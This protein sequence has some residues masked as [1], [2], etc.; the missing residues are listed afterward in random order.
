MMLTPDDLT[1]S[2]SGEGLWADHPLHNALLNLVFKLPMKAFRECEPFKH[3][4][5]WTPCSA[6][7]THASFPSPQCVVNGQASLCL[8]RTQ[9]GFTAWGQWTDFTVLGPDSS[10]VQKE[11]T[12]GYRSLGRTWSTAAP[13][14]WLHVTVTGGNKGPW[15]NKGN[16]LNSDAGNLRGNKTRCRK[17][18]EMGFLCTHDPDWCRRVRPTQPPD[19]APRVTHQQF[20]KWLHPQTLKLGSHVHSLQGDFPPR[21][22]FGVTNPQSPGWTPFPDLETGVTYPQSPG[23]PPSPDPIPGVTCPQ[24][25]GWPLSLDPA[26]WFPWPLV[27]TPGLCWLSSY[28]GNEWVPVSSC[29]DR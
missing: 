16:T 9:V 19:P 26:P 10:G 21:P 3:R 7:T 28:S 12:T 13:G 5:P 29:L 23:W 22:A 11:L 18:A 25:P 1:T 4:L 24:S 14:A 27:R 17:R 8:G 6:P 20:L 15:A 2:Q